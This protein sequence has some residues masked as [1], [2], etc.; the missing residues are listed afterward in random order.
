MLNDPTSFWHMHCT[1]YRDICGS[2]VERLIIASTIG[3]ESRPTR[4]KHILQASCKSFSTFYWSKPC[5]KS[6]RFRYKNF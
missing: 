1:I 4:Q 6:I 3:N 2:P 5:P